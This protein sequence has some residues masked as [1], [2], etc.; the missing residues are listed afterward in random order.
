MRSLSCLFPTIALAITI[1]AADPAP[2]QDRGPDPADAE[3]VKALLQRATRAMIDKDQKTFV[4]CCDDYVDCFFLDGTLIKG[5]K[6]IAVTLF[7]FF[8]RRPESTVVRLDVVPRSYR[9]LSPDIMMVDW[10]ATITGPGGKVTVN[11]LTTVRKAE[12][13]WLITS[14]LESVPYTA[15]IGGRNAEPKAP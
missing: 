11:T 1:G 3:A 2:A 13:R 9:V 8:R 7:E 15:R 5:K 14:Y 4:A 6:R 12:G 10:P